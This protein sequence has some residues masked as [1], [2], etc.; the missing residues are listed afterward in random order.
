M[1]ASDSARLPRAARAR[2]EQPL[3]DLALRHLGNAPRRARSDERD[4]VR[5]AAETS[6]GELSTITIAPFAASFARARARPSTSRARTR[7][8]LPGAPLATDRGEDVGR[9]LELE[10]ARRRLAAD[11]VARHLRRPVVRDGRR[12]DHDVRVLA[13]SSIARSSRR[14]RHAQQLDALGR[15]DARG[16]L[17][18][19]T[20]AP[21]SRAASANAKPI[22]RSSGS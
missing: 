9:R 22:R 17:T 8:H 7:H 18:S 16:P 20:I 4:A 2:V 5:V 12:H 21:R 3:G 11:L 10:R 13:A 1:G 14:G 6:A 19:V 15:L